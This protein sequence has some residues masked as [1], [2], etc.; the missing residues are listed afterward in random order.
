MRIEPD[1]VVYT[2]HWIRRQ[3]FAPRQIWRKADG[4]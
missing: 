1:R 4:S 3:G 2:E